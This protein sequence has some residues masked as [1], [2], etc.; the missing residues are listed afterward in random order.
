M[1][2]LLFALYLKE[3]STLLRSDRFDHIND[4]KLLQELVINN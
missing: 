1:S 2:I 3:T 4:I